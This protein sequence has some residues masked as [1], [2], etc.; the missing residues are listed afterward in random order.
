MSGSGDSLIYIRFAMKDMQE[1]DPGTQTAIC[2]WLEVIT[3]LDLHGFAAGHRKICKGQQGG[4]CG[5][6]FKHNCLLNE[7]CKGSWCRSFRLYEL[8]LPSDIHPVLRVYPMQDKR[9]D[10]KKHINMI[11]R[12]IVLKSD[13][14]RKF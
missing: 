14:K 1:K 3:A 7:K 12:W 6:N 11:F 13:K 5:S 10:R 8:I 4:P 9:H 2:R